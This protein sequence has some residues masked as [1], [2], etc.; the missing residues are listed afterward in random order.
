MIRE[1][2]K[3]NHLLPARNPYV[4]RHAADCPHPIA[5]LAGFLHLYEGVPYG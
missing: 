3:L 2:E 4:V 1:H 5:F